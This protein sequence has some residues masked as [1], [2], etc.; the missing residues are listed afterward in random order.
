MLLFLNIATQIEQASGP[1]TPESALSVSQEEGKK[2][3]FVF[4]SPCPQLCYHC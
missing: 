4:P 2:G 1:T 3:G